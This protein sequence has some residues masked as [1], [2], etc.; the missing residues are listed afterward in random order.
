MLSEDVLGRDKIAAPGKERRGNGTL[1]QG[2]EASKANVG[3]NPPGVGGAKY[4]GDD[5]Y[6]PESVPDS[7]AAEGYIPPESVTQSSRETE[8]YY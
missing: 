1:E 5:Y 4:R 8:G 2:V 6:R 7:V 3:R